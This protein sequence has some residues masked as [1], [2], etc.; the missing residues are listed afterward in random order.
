M[1]YHFEKLHHHGQSM[2]VGKRHSLQFQTIGSL[3]LL[4][5]VETIQ[6]P[7]SWK[8]L[9]SKSWKDVTWEE[10]QFKEAPGRITAFIQRERE[11]SW[12]L[13]NAKGHKEIMKKVGN[14]NCK[15]I[16]TFWRSCSM[17]LGHCPETTRSHTIVHVPHLNAGGPRDCV[18]LRV[19][20]QC[21]RSTL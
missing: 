20:E 4:Q 14:A 1:E 9:E 18:A 8:L 6:A 12:K 7:S 5:H 2:K 17:L 19:S 15:L 16:P 11:F 13:Y 21:F 3:R 10:K